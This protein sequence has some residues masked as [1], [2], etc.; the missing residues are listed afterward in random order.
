M[1]PYRRN[2]RHSSK[3]IKHIIRVLGRTFEKEIDEEINAKNRI[4]ECE[5]WPEGEDKIKH[6]MKI[7]SDYWTIADEKN[8]QK[9]LTRMINYM[10]YKDDKTGLPSTIL[11]EPNLINSIAASRYITERKLTNN[12]LGISILETYTYS[13]NQIEGASSSNA[14]PIRR[15]I[16]RRRKINKRETKKKSGLEH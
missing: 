16:K 2:Y 7:Y 9:Y 5:N 8:K 11:E 13:S 14:G 12:D 3:L 1:Y 10:R 15:V 4:K 6:L